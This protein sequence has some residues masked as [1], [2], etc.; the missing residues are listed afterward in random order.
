MIWNHDTLDTQEKQVEIRISDD[1]DADP[2]F[3]T[4]HL[5]NGALNPCLKK[6]SMSRVDGLAISI[7]PSTFDCLRQSVRY[8]PIQPSHHHPT[9]V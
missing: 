3:F 2:D 5:A 7:R 8:L 6:P 1:I 4:K 9:Q